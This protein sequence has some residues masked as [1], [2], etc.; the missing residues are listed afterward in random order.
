MDYRDDEEF[1]DFIEYS[2]LGLPLAYAFANGI[3]ESSAMGE[4]FVIEAFTLFLAGL[5]IEDTGF[6]TLQEILEASPK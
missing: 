3:V 4:D 6:E 5:G 2:D 1:K